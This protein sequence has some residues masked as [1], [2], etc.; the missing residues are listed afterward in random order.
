M[1]G[2]DGDDSGRKVA[3]LSRRD[4]I[5]ALVMKNLCSLAKGMNITDDF[6]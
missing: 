5:L 2:I 6:Y 1:G 3:S 4:G